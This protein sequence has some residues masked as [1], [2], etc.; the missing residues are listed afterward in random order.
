MDGIDRQLDEAKHRLSNGQAT[1]YF[2]LNEQIIYCLQN[3]KDMVNC[4][5]NEQTIYCLL[6]D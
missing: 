3:D 4:L 6:N 1:V 5:L 2:L